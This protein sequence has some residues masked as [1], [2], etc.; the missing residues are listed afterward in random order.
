MRILSLFVFAFFLS[1]CHRQDNKKSSMENDKSQ[2]LP[3]YLIL[4]IEKFS[5][6]FN[7]DMPDSNG[8]F[9]YYSQR[10]DTSLLVRFQK[11]SGEVF[12]MLYQ[13]LPAYHRSDEDFADEKDS[14][15]FFEGYSFRI[16]SAQW[17]GIMREANKIMSRE[18]GPPR[19]EVCLDCPSYFLAYSSKVRN[20]YSEDRSLFAVF[21]S[22]LK[23]SLLN[24]FVA[25]RQPKPRRITKDPK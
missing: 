12:G 18:E 17:I 21:A 19:N 24:Q 4:K 1:S 8:L 23:H 7:E 15:L 20:S 22:Y 11:R 13:V 10:F 5:L 14:L 6:P 2:R 16:D 9:F 3:A 25:D